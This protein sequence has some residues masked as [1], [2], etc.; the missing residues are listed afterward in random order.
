MRTTKANMLILAAAV[1]AS[2]TTWLGPGAL[3]DDD[4]KVVATLTV[5][6]DA[7]LSKPADQLRLDVGVTTEAAEATA[8]LDA[9]SQRMSE[10]IAALKKMRLTEDEYQTGRFDIRIQ[11]ERRPRQV[12]PEWRPRI[13]GYEVSN[14]L[15]IKTKRLDIAGRLIEAVNKAGANSINSVVFD[16]A[17]RRAYR[18]EAITAAT[19]NARKDAADLA[20]AASLKLVRILSISLDD[21]AR[22]PPVPLA[23]AEGFAVAAAAP[24]PPIEPGDVTVRASVTIVYEIASL[25]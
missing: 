4:D 5:R 23:R 2:M 8:A 21:A 15:S 1:A 6:G 18:T 7:E 19:A 25:E 13:I 24:A 3:A 16:L 11:Y 9:N 10:V 20:G 12:E 22:Q 17:D 14:T